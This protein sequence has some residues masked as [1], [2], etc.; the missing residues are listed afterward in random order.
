VVFTEKKQE[1]S[2]SKIALYL[3]VIQAFDQNEPSPTI[4]FE[5]KSQIKNG[6]SGKIF[7]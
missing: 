2:P 6:A 1:S 5:I 7:L 3:I 4:G